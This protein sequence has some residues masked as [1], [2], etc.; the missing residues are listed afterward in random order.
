MN[1]GNDFNEV[2][3]QVGGAGYIDDCLRLDHLESIV[4]E[5]NRWVRLHIRS[6]FRD[7]TTLSV[8]N[9]AHEFWRGSNRDHGRFINEMFSFLEQWMRNKGMYRFANDGQVQHVLNDIVFFIVAWFSGIDY[10][11]RGYI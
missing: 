8:M 5:L 10:G 3:N 2:F 4:F 9:K 6:R 7:L 11:N 1:N